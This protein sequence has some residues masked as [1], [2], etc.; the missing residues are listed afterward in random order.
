M[1]GHELRRPEADFLRDGIYEL[2]IRVG[3]VHYRVLYFFDGQG[4]AVLV[5]GL[6]KEGKVPAEEIDRAI[7]RK[8]AFERKPDNHTHEVIS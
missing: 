8:R 3:R 4:R 1:L 7:R 2:R 6:V 5:Q